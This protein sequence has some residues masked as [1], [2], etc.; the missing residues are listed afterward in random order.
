MPLKRDP[1]PQMAPHCGF[2]ADLRRAGA[3]CCAGGTP[4]RYVAASR[5]SPRRTACRSGGL[6]NF[7]PT[8]STCRSLSCPLAVV[9]P[10]FCLEPVLV[11]SPHSPFSFCRPTQ[12]KFYTSSVCTILSPP[13]TLAFWL[14]CTFGR[15]EGIRA[16]L[17]LCS[18]VCRCLCNDVNVNVDK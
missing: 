15:N 2:G 4:R 9:S 13:H 3:A 12:T 1:R 7:L 11:T 6:S 18:S 17:A 10:A 14:K 16:T 5:S 8:R